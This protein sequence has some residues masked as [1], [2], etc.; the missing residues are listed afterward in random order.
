MSNKNRI[1]RLDFV[2]FLQENAYL[3]SGL[4]GRKLRSNIFFTDESF[5]EI[6]P[7]YNPHNCR[8]RTE[9][10]SQVH[11]I[12]NQKFQKIIMI[13]GGFSVFSVSKLHFI[14]NNEKIDKKY[15]Q[16]KILPVYFEATKSA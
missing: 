6:S 8:Y 7:K 14:E 16:E 15:Y 3:T 5:I 4:R 2:K 12:E 10:R 13:P 9:N 11:I 1:D